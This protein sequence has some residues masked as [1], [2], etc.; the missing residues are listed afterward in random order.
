MKGEV[1]QHADRTGDVEI[2]C[3]VCII[4]SGAGGAVLAAGLCAQGLDVV[5]L[6]AGPYRTRADFTMQ[7]AI[8]YP[9][10]YQERAARG[11][12][13]LAISVFQGR[14]VGGSTTVNWTTCFRTPDAIR[15][16]WAERYGLEL[17][18]DPHF[19]AVEER[20]NVAPWPE[21]LANPNNRVIA[22]GCAA[23]GLEWNSLRR[24]VKG[25][26]NTGYCGLGCPVD[27]KQAMGITYL[28]DA[29]EDGLVLHADV[30]VDR[31]ETR[32]RR[33]VA[34]HGRSGP[35]DA[36]V[37]S[38]PAVVVRPTVCVSS[39]GAINGPA[40][41]L[42]SRLD[43]G[44]AVGRR[45]F[46]HPVVGSLALFDDPINPF[47]GAPQ[48]MGSH[49]FAHR[50][51][52]RIGYFLEAAPLQP[53]LAALAMP[54]AGAELQTWMAKLPHVNGLIALAIDGVLPGDDG[55]TV[56]ITPDGRPV[57]RYAISAALQEAF[58]DAMQNLARIQLAAGAARVGSGHVPPIEIGS[59]ADVAKLAEA[60]YAA[61]DVTVFTAHQMGGC[62][63]GTDP[64]ASVVDPS[65][66]FRGMDN[67]FV[68]DGSVLPTSLG[69]NPS[70][71]IYAL[72]HR[73]TPFVGEAV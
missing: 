35:P 26:A 10:L 48:S 40:L 61:H 73:A 55:G 68:V 23:L 3:D 21:A 22:D 16:L 50:G 54:L 37:K 45:T 38:G 57:L 39:G 19:E 30:E 56:G 46:V 5:I 58:A 52:D 70:E 63:M 27:G 59:E 31:L 6:E 12:E 62:L 8:A 51:D 7:E 47:Y 9:D 69:V 42:R 20:L 15:A 71:T 72:A 64:A 34:V 24:N 17:D 29:L 67:L 44:G 11:T 36:P 66:R 28:R 41:L 13:D 53:M 2:T 60:S 4:G 32:G 65:Y 18:L 43:A 33:V 49:A 1:V 14:S 25:C